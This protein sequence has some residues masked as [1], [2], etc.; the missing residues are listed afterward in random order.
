LETAR[1]GDVPPYVVFSDA[2]LAAI[3]QAKPQTL[4]ALKNV[5][6]IGE[7]KLKRYGAAVLAITIAGF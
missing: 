7:A 3:V 5:P 6:G 1:A 2:T 4:P